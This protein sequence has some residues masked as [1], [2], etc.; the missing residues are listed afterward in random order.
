MDISVI[1]VNYN[2]KHF[3]EQCLCSL[4]KAL[5]GLAA[6]IIVVDNFSG[7]GS[8]EFLQKHFPGVKIIRNVNNEGF[9]KANN[10]GL[11]IAKGKYILFLNPDTILSENSIRTPLAFMYSN[12][13]AGALGI[14]MID[15]SGK[16]LPESK[17]GFPSPWVSFC[18]M[19]GLTRLFPKSSLFARYYLGHLSSTMNQEVEALA[20]A[21]MLIRKEILDQLGG[22]DERFFMYAEDIDLS[23]RIRALGYR[24]YYFADATIIHFKGE[25][26][27]KDPV[28]IKNFYKAMNQFVD[29]HY[30]K[31]SP[32]AARLLHWA[33]G[34][35]AWLAG[36]T[37][38]SASTTHPQ[39]MVPTQFFLKGDPLATSKAAEM[40]KQS[41]EAVSIIF[42][43]GERFTYTEAIAEMEMKKE[44]N[45]YFIHGFQTRSAVGS[46]SSLKQGLVLGPL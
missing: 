20:G 28:Y 45:F 27:S 17:R 37:Q 22:F 41:P 29:K 25:S 9:G 13:Q 21:F 46:D 4:Q 2:V 15:G 3:L 33:I 44:K 42:C 8:I 6:E 39:R 10:K 30:K 14:R 12:V 40:Y 26:T 16:Y 23:Y 34:F 19:I 18:K 36:I 38:R 5:E 32:L 35:R 1:I 11:E 43:I 24:N 31:R 7:D